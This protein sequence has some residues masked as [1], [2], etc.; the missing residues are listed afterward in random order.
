VNEH[1]TVSVVIATHDRPTLLR[2]AVRA[3]LGQDHPGPIECVVVFDGVDVDPLEDVARAGA[4]HRTV[5]TVANTRTPGLAGARNSGALIA[6]GGLLAWCDD[7]DEWLP[8]KISRQLEALQHSASHVAVTGI[9]VAF[10]GRLSQRIPPALVTRE[11]LLHGRATAVHPSTV[12][13]D[14][15]AFRTIGPIDEEIPG[16]YGEDYDWLLRA[17]AAGPIVGVPEALV[18]V[19]RGGSMFAD[20]WQTIIDAI[21]YLT[22]KH[23][24]L[25]DDDTNA[26]RLFGRVAFAN[27][28]LR[29]R[30]DA[31]R[32]AW[33]SMRRR[34]LEGRSYLALAVASGVVHA[35]TIQRRANRAGRG[36]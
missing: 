31:V 8:T 12:L 7:D 36:V 17:A 33:R 14:T 6:T 35:S 4:H 20:R 11:L 19:H 23:P 30:R 10:D 34:P 1:P 3:V 26:A 28:A 9:N 25:L 24:E 27:A 29:R 18:T 15:G 22:T 13:V 32:W 5:I 2:R 21:G 16:S